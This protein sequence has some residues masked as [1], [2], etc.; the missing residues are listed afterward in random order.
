MD[1]LQ[2]EQP[3]KSSSEMAKGKECRSTAF[4]YATDRNDSPD[5]HMP[6]VPPFATDANQDLFLSS[7]P[8]I[9]L[10]GKAIGRLE[11]P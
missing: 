2:R 10:Q 11:E 1:A 8:D 5:I 4:S 3:Q 7:R 6:N 9:G